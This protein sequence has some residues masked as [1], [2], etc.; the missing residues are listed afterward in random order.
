MKEKNDKSIIDIGP[1][2]LHSAH[3]GYK[4]GLAKLNFDFDG[5]AYDLWYFFKNSSARK[6]DFQLSELISEVKTHVMIKHI[7][8]RWLCIKKVAIRITDQWQNLKIYFLE[9]L[10]NQ[11][12]F[13][14]DIETTDRYQKI[15]K[16]LT[17]KTSLIYLGFAVHIADLFEGFM[18]LLQSKKP[19][20]HV[21]YSAIGDLYFK[22][23]GNFVKHEKLIDSTK[24]KKDAARLGVIDLNNNKNL[25]SLHE[26]D[27]GKKAKHQIAMIEND[28]NVDII[29]TEMKTCLIEMTSYLQRKLPH[30]NKLIA[31]I[32]FIHPSKR[33]DLK[34]LPAIGRVAE[35][36]SKVLRGTKFSDISVDR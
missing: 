9:Y 34:A 19:V 7:A 20:I 10:P 29:K 3:N 21:L 31:D 25:K 4:A 32:Q 24:N 22:L 6:E 33:N 23:M 15:R 26:I 16:Y 36:F 28:T 1:C 30:G 18:D 35:K 14:K 11:K 13:A 12:G 27:Y 5:F 2:V 17:S 8:S